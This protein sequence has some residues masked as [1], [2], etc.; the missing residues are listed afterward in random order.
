MAAKTKIAIQLGRRSVQLAVLRPGTFGSIAA[1]AVT[2]P[3]PEGTDPAD[4]A[5][6]G[7][8]VASI[9]EET[10]SRGA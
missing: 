5:A 2:R 10:G 7:A 1:S 9:L 3:L 4:A 8:V 6:V